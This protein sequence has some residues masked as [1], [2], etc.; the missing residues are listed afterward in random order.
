MA[1]DA[2]KNER[3]ASAHV[4]STDVLHASEDVVANRFRLSP[5]ENIRTKSIVGEALDGIGQCVPS[6]LQTNV[7]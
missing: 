2:Q 4:V 3:S 7:D 1:E 5:L 6:Q